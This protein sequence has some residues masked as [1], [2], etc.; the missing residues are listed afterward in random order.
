MIEKIEIL[1]H[2]EYGNFGG[3][4]CEKTSRLLH[5]VAYHHELV[6][7]LR[8]ERLDSL[9]EMF[10]GPFRRIPVLLS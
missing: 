1:R 10:V 8:K 3:H 7:K 9:S 5:I 2:R 6:V 4:P